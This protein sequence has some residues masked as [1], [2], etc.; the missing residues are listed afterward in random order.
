[1]LTPSSSERE[2]Q[3]LSV[4]DSV[5]V[6]V[7]IQGKSVFAEAKGNIKCIDGD[8]IDVEIECRDGNKGQLTVNTGDL[9]PSPAKGGWDLTLQVKTSP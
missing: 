7:T 2:A 1:M 5:N 4:G 3:M 6:T 9:K 8:K